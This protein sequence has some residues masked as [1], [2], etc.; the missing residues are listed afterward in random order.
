MA[1]MLKVV[2]RPTPNESEE[3][4]I[5]TVQNVKRLSRRS[6]ADICESSPPSWR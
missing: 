5:N 2:S 4:R 6:S 3:S 1:L